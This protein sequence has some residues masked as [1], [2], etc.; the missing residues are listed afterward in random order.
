M[1]QKR[2]C[3]DS[4]SFGRHKGNGA[5]CPVRDWEEY[6]SG[7]TSHLAPRSRQTADE[8]TRGQHGRP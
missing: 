7:Y 1:N 2:Q 8:S 5:R 6:S 4:S 3:P